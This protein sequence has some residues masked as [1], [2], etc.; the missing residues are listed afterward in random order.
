MKQ[1]IEIVVSVIAILIV[2]GLYWVMGF[3]IGLESQQLMSTLTVGQFVSYG[4]SWIIH[5][6]AAWYVVY[7]H[8]KS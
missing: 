7:G 4:F 8:K 2:W 1:I 6:W 5:M 3:R